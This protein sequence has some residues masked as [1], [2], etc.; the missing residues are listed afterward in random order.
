MKK[1]CIFLLGL[2][3][4]AFC[5]CPV[6]AEQ[7]LPAD[8][9]YS[10]SGMEILHSAYWQSP[11]GTWFVL[12]R[13]P[14]GMNM[15]LCFELRDG[16]WVQSFHTSAA[17]PQGKAGVKRLYIT[18]KVQDYV[19]NK[20]AFGPILLI[21]TD[22]GGYYSFQRSD[23][24]QWNLFKVFYQEEQVHLD[25]DDESVKFR[26]PVDQDHS[27]IETVQGVFERD[28]RKVDLNRIP[29]SPQQALELLEE[30][31]RNESE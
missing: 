3:L 10:M 6:L 22:D 14:N 31:K 29:R 19:Y 13:T 7:P 27:R 20:T 8:I 26:T 23:S 18:D 12:I 4:A 2:M 28:L 17:V 5:V 21:L 16:V 30:M 1:T 9:R 25:F 24:G 15:L 11:G